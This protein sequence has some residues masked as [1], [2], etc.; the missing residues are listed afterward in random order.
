MSYIDPENNNQYLVI[1]TDDKYS[2]LAKKTLMAFESVY[3]NFDFDFIFRTNTSSFIDFN[4]LESYI[5]NNLESLSFSGRLVDTVEG[6]TIASGAGF[7]ISKKNVELIL[8][9]KSTFDTTLPDDVAVAKI[10]LS[11]NIKPQNLDRL[12]LKA[13]PKPKYIYENNSFHYR[14][15]LDPQFHRILEPFL[16]NYLN[17]VSSNKNYVL[18]IIYYFIARA[19]FQ[20]SNIKL[21]KKIIQKYYSYK[22]YG[23]INLGEKVIFKKNKFT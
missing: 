3:N 23:I 13:V 6:L 4:K 17:F 12:D 9:N 22:F 1:D 21:V 10:L 7:F 8:K 14:C 20:I 2:N 19:L 15:R 11:N 16:F 18:K 5:N